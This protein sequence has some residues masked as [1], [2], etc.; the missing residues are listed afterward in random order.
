[1]PAMQ[2]QEPL[3]ETGFVRLPQVLRVFP[4]SKS[5]WWAGVKAHKYPQPVKLSAKISAWRA[6]DIRLLIDAYVVASDSSQYHKG[7]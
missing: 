2:T 4:V 6:E 5:H 7:K 3:P 1:M